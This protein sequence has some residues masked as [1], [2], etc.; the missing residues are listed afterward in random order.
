MVKNAKI[1]AVYSS[2]QDKNWP[3]FLPPRQG[4]LLRLCTLCS[5]Q[6]PCRGARGLNPDCTLPTHSEMRVVACVCLEEGALSSHRG[7][8][9]LPSQGLHLPRAAPLSNWHRGPAFPPHPIPRTDP[10]AW[11]W[12]VITSWPS[13][14]PVCSLPVLGLLTWLIPG[15]WLSSE[16]PFVPR[17]PPGCWRR[18]WMLLVL[19]FSPDSGLQNI[20]A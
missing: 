18:P 10:E 3:W 2:I 15:S 13:S 11:G 7:I 16:L 8:H 5:A 20:K 12:F 17:L 19:G 6:R 9:C 14:C 4:R 1:W